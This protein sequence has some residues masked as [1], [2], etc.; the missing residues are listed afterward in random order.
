MPSSDHSTVVTR[1]AERLERIRLALRSAGMDALVCALPSNVLLLSGYWPVVGTS[2]AVATRE[3]GVGLVVPADEEDMAAVGWADVVERFTPGSLDALVPLT[4]AVAPAVR[5]V[6][7]RLGVAT[8]HIGFE[9]GPMLEPSSYAGTNRYIGALR[10]VLSEC[11]PS[12]NLVEADEILLELRAVLTRLEL[13]GV[14]TACRVAEDAFRAGAASIVPGAT[15]RD[16]AASFRA[17]LAAYADA[18]GEGSARTG[19]FVFCMSGPNAAMADRAYARTR[20]RR[21]QPGDLVMVHCNS[22]VSG[23]W[24]D[25]TRTYH[26]GPTE[27]G[28]RELFEAVLAARRVALEAVAPGV[29]ASE[30]DRAARDELASRGLGSAFRHGAGH[31]VGFAAIDHNARPRLHPRSPDVL[32]PGMVFNLEPAI[33]LDGRGGLRHCD[34]VA[35]HSEGAELLTPFHTRLEELA[36]R[37]AAV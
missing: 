19:G 18:Y 7:Q 23:L 15:E 11:A 17:T 9:H 2:I 34:V 16:I 5:R 12:A 31:G 6:F 20:G 28:A 22:F 27:D 25:I 10:T 30:V 21:V 4:D 26:P 29:R 36:P 35:V 24:T 32:E 3:G 13:A 14:R 33:Y 8:A 37:L 1:D